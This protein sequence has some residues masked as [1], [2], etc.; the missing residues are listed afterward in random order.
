MFKNYSLLINL[1]LQLTFKLV[2][3]FIHIPQNGNDLVL[4]LKLVLIMG[5]HS[6]NL[7]LNHFILPVF[8][9]FTVHECPEWRK[10][11]FLH[12]TLKDVKPMLFAPFLQ[13]LQ[14][15]HFKTKLRQVIKHH[16]LPLIFSSLAILTDWWYHRLKI[17]KV[18]KFLKF[19]LLLS[20][21]KYIFNLRYNSFS[22]WRFNF[23]IS[24]VFA[25]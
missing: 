23:L 10:L 22:F 15:V 25:K 9:F 14:L 13:C 24:L 2:Q 17:V 11:N 18:L 12:D 1:L 21:F 7:L 5:K 20:L 4:A 19:Q 6:G 16:F 8:N 3:F